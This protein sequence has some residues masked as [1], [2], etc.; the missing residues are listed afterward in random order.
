M[1]SFLRSKG[2]VKGDRVTL[3]MPMVPQLP[4]AMLACARIGAVHSVVFG[5]FSAEA[6]A[7]RLIDGQCKVIITG[8]GVMR[9]PKPIGLYD[10]VKE[11]I[12]ICDKAGVPIETCLVLQRL[13]NA[14][15][16]TDLAKGRDI[17][18]HDAIPKASP[19]CEVEWVDSEDSLF[20]LYTAT[21][22]KYVFDLKPDDIF[23]C[24]ADCGWIT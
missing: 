3:F 17:W 2:V 19:E 6:L 1:G 22:S 24:T 7:G 14:T 13:D 11:S 4:I 10:I 23:F 12:Q 9:G 16:P 21:T 8:N 20:V 5:G 18:W 15:M